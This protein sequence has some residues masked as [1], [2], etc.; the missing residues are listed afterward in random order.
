MRTQSFGNL[1]TDNGKP[2]LEGQGDLVSS[3]SSRGD[4]SGYSMRYGEHLPIQKVPLTWKHSLVKGSWRW[5][6][7]TPL[8]VASSGAGTFPRSDG[9]C[10][11]GI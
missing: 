7:H 8:V 10:R 4:I 3:I 11:N 9:T 6:Q 1:Y 2:D 5:T